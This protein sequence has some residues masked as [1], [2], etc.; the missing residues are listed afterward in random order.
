MLVTLKDSLFFVQVVRFDPNS[1]SSRMFVK[2]PLSISWIVLQLVLR[3]SNGMT[4]SQIIQI[5]VLPKQLFAEL[6]KATQE[7]LQKLTFYFLSTYSR[8]ALLDCCVWV[9]FVTFVLR[10]LQ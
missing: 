2:M 8:K 5:N 6:L 10:F 7:L 4:Q 1:L 3:I 9:I